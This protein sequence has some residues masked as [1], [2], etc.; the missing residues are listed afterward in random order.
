MHGRLVILGLCLFEPE[1][2]RQLV[3]ADIFRLLKEELRGYTFDQILTRR[4]H[5]LYAPPDSVFN[6]SD[7]PLEKLEDDLLG[8]A[9]FASFLKDRIFA[10]NLERRAYLVYLYG[11]RTS[12]KNMA[13]NFKTWYT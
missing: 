5:E 2:R 12:S 10:I 7:N 4:G 8:R 3:A 6:Q 9:A 13:L 1:L 11:A